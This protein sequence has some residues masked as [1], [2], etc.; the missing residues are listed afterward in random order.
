[1]NCYCFAQ[2][3]YE[4]ANSI[5]YRAFLKDSQQ[6]V[7]LKCFEADAQA[8]YLR[9]MSSF[10]IESPYLVA[11][12]DTFY[13]ND[14]RPCVVYEF[15]EEGTL[16]DW[17]KQHPENDAEFCYGL[18][19][20]MLHALIYLNGN[21]RIHCD[22][23]PGNIFLRKNA[24]GGMDFILGDLG[25]T[26]SLREAQESRYGI[27]TP[28]YIAP[29]RLYD[30]F[31]Y[32]SDLYS[33]GVVAFEMLAGERPFTG[34]PEDVKRAALSKP[35]DFERIDPLPLRSF[36]ERLM[37]K[38]PGIRIDSAETALQILTALRSGE[39]ISEPVT[40]ASV[41]GDEN[42][43][44]ILPQR[45]L[46]MAR[47]SADIVADKAHAFEINGSLLLGLE[48]DNHIDL[49]N[50]ENGKRDIVLKNG[51]IQTC[52][53]SGFFYL[54]GLKV[55]E[56]DLQAY[57]QHCVYRFNKS[58][59]YFRHGA[60]HLLLRS[61]Y[62]N[63]Y[64]NLQTKQPLKF[65]QPH[66]FSEPKAC[67]LENGDFCLSGGNSNQKVIL[68]DSET[69]VL[70]GWELKGPVMTL[71]ATEDKVLA[72]TLDMEDGGHC[73]I[74]SL[75][76]HPPYSMSFSSQQISRHCHSE[77]SLFWIDSDN[78]LFLCEDDLVPKAIGEL[79][80]ALSIASFQVSYNHRWLV[81][82]SNHEKQQKIICFKADGE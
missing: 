19:E 54:N 38:D 63:V 65:P 69:Q 21:R 73:W 22:I 7:V 76:P 61:K 20:S 8:M 9:E 35:A 13:L 78:R 67:I 53:S 15:F 49:L 39:R 1:M 23:K 47:L 16:E 4:S 66:Y 56:F 32:N 74:C 40:T 75:S 42:D 17:L 45:Y 70:H 25:A 44:T 59:N 10:G 46:E 58:I 81:A 29:E 55:Q 72:L 64:C 82:L 34:T 6:Q 33:L 50:P 60:G 62:D 71:L 43:R 27:G 2:V 41:T 51:Q 18:L 31:Y 80:Q 26:C 48:F 30:R 11:C 79:P 52:R 77:N 14:S 3:L 37:E 36:I 68:R 28:A 57:R 12:T 24:K 5:L